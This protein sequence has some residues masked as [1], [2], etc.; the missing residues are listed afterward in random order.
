MVRVGGHSML[1]PHRRA[2]RIP[3]TT[4]TYILNQ[5]PDAKIKFLA[6]EALC[7]VDRLAFAANGKR[8][9]NEPKEEE[10]EEEEEEEADEEAEEAE[11]EAAGEVP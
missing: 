11:E 7:T 2:E 6:A 8:I 5:M 3:G 4:I 1:R 10:Q 9:A